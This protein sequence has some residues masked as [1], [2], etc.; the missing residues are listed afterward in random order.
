MAENWLHGSAKWAELDDLKRND[1]IDG[2]GT[3]CGHTPKENSDEYARVTFNGDSHMLTVA[4]TRSEKGTT[5]IIPSLMEHKGGVLCIDPKGENAIITAQARENLHGQ[6]VQVFD[7]WGITKGALGRETACFNPL[8]MLSPDSENLAD[9]A[10]GIAD[11]LILQD[12]GDSHWPNEAR[13]MVMGF[14]VHLVT[15]PQEE[16][17]RHLGRLREI[18]SLPPED[19]Q[20][21]V[22]DMSENGVKLAK[23]AANRLMQK[24]ERELSSVISTAQQNTHFLESDRVQ[25]SLAKST[26]D[27]STLA[28]DENALSA[29]IVLPAD[30]LNTHGRLLRLMVSQAITAMVRAPKKPKTSAL[31]LLDEFA[32]L[33]KLASV[34]QAFGLMAGFGMQIHAILQDLSQ[35]QD[36]YGQRWQT[37]VGNAGMLK[38]FGTRDLM[39]AEYASKLCGQTTVERISVATAEKRQGEKFMGVEIEPEDPNYTSMADQSFGRALMM[40]EEV[41]RLQSHMQLMFLPQADPLICRKVPYYKNARYYDTDGQPLFNPHPNYPMPEK[42][43]FYFWDQ[44][45][46]ERF[47]GSPFAPEDDTPEDDTPKK[48]RWFGKG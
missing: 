48:K 21:L 16:G 22:V 31:F 18:L 9:D 35:L 45:T 5:Q 38:F 8:D 23:N 32:S 17:K 36:L 46:I 13:A 12:K 11:D 4:P 7:P 43:T 41:M 47:E 42:P 3:I 20:A 44:E 27:F 2:E 1:F 39:T 26:F 24:S 30:R 6:E 40:P 14:I 10:M 34:E 37:F 29:F 28:N 33:G 19:F 25:A 15:S